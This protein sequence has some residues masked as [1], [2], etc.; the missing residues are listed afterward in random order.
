MNNHQMIPDEEQKNVMLSSHQV[1]VILSG[2]IVTIV[3]AFGLGYYIGQRE[4]LVEYT[5]LVTK[6]T[7]A[8]QIYCSLYKKPTSALTISAEDR[9][10]TISDIVEDQQ[11]TL[12]VPEENSLRQFS[13]IIAG[14]PDHKKESANMMVQR[15]QERGVRLAV[16]ER[17]GK[18]SKGVTRIWYQVV[19][20][21]M[22]HEETVKNIVATIQQQEHIKKIT[23]QEF[24]ATKG[25]CA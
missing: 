16:K 22:S 18:N 9:L 10:A 13:A 20:E 5:S 21:P 2:L 1:V 24:D 11:L 14:F 7:L 17:K 15:W 6:Q 3:I 19:L 12:T 4:Q 25:D 23:I 8:D